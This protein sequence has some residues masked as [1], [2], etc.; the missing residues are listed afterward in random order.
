MIRY[1]GIKP[2]RK[3]SYCSYTLSA[4]KAMIMVIVCFKFNVWVHC[5][6][7]VLITVSINKRIGSEK[8]KCFSSFWSLI[9]RN[10]IC[11]V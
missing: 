1:S 11:I 2:N 9:D 5:K 8:P 4:T 10:I 3:V 7:Q 6:V